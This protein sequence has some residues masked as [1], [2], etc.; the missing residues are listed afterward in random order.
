MIFEKRVR[1]ATLLLFGLSAGLSNIAPANAQA[2]ADELFLEENA[3]KPGVIKRPSGLQIR[4][5]RRGKGSFPNELSVVQ[6]QYEG[7]LIDGSV[8]DSSF[9][10]GTPAEFQVMGVIDGWMEA[11]LMM[12]IGSKWELVIPAKIAYGDRGAGDG[13]IPPGATLIFEV[14]LVAILDQ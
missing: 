1:L 7:K 6:V 9:E 12:Q 5:I 2:S 13:V 8:F 4:V 3:K 10:R 14:E 11:L